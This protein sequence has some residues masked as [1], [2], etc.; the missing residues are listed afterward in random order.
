MISRSTSAPLRSVG[1]QV[2]PRDEDRDEFQQRMK[3]NCFAAAVI[4]ALLIFGF[5]LVDAMVDVQKTQGCYA[6]GVHSCSLI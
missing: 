3:M 4:I 2:A 5:W 6:S 1:P